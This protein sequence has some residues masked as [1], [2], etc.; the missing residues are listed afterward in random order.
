AGLSEI[1]THGDQTMDT[2]ARSGVTRKIARRRACG[3]GDHGPVL[4]ARELS[5]EVG[6]RLTLVEASFTVRAGE[7][8]G[9]VGRN[10]AGKTSLLRVLAGEAPAA[11]GTV[12]RRGALGY[13]PQEPRPAG[14]GV[15][16]T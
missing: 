16:A 4:Q 7:T 12:L 9:L 8:V 10:G 2:M 5:V 3:R 6:G 1:A 13:L 11:G 14:A 15:D